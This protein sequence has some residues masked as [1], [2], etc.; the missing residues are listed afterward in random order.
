MSKQTLIDS[1]DNV[2]KQQEH[3]SRIAG[4]GFQRY[5]FELVRTGLTSLDLV[6]HGRVVA[7]VYGR[8]RG[9]MDLWHADGPPQVTRRLAQHEDFYL[10]SM[11]MRVQQA[12]LASGLH[13]P[14]K[15]EPNPPKPAPLS[16]DGWAPMNVGAH[17]LF[18]NGVSVARAFKRKNSGY[19]ASVTRGSVV[20][21]FGPFD[22]LEEA[23]AA[24]EWRAAVGAAL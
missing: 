17:V 18:H 4:P 22:T 7:S 23:K 10:S 3:D 2:M 13:V 6:V 21:N 16:I 9:N 11:L 24:A 5:S 15:R 14:P 12:V 20:G 1:L 8:T 19:H